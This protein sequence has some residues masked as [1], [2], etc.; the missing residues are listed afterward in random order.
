MPMYTVDSEEVQT[1]ASSIQATVGR[2]QSES[3]LLHGQLADLQRSWTGQAA[4]AFQASA[5]EWRSVQVRLDEALTALGAA[6]AAAG[7]SYADAEQSA[8]A[9]FR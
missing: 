4:A 1:K 6:L 9:M 8:V 2:M 5:E 7:T 3:G